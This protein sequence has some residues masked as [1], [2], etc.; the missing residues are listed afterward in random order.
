M[1]VY[2]INF[3]IL[4]AQFIF[5]DVMHTTLTNFQ[6]VPIYTDIFQSVHQDTLNQIQLNSTSQDPSWQAQ[7][8]NSFTF[9]G[10]A[11]KIAWNLLLLITGF[12]VFGVMFDLGVPLIF[13]LAFIGL[14]LILLVRSIPGWI[15]SI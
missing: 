1:F 11:A 13:V 10:A 12:Y 14:Y 2:S 5:A 3:S 6:G 15:R 7:V 9:L 4:G 8:Q